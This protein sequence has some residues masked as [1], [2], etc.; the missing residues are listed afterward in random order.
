MTKTL[1]VAL[2]A[3]GLATRL[4]PI[5]ER[6]PKSL[7]EI[8]GEPFIIHQLRLL[9]REGVT[10]VVLCIGYLGEMVQRVVGDGGALGL[11]VSYSLDGPIL[12]GTGGAIRQA[13]PLLGPEFIIMY[14]DSYL[15]I[16]YQQ[17]VDRYLQTGLDGLMTVFANAGRWDVSNIEFKDGQI[18]Q[19]SKH[20]TPQM[21][22][23]DYG[24]GIVKATAFADIITDGPFDLSEVYRR[25]IARKQMA[26]YLVGK[27]FYEIGSRAGIADL[28]ALL[29]S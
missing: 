15:D 17:I 12:R 3:G 1:P 8:A 4:R 13:L 20:P 24:L 14:G 10:N 23:I 7:V 18:V 11:K 9:K 21:Q 28:E 22:H 19:Y 6:I 27:R 16:H 25:L 29:S 2:L 5:T 26:G